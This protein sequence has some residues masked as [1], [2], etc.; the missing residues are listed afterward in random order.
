M[1]RPRQHNGSHLDFVRSLPCLICAD[2]TSTEAAHI[3]YG[4][5]RVAKRPAGFGEKSDDAFTVPMCGLHHRNQHKGNE[6]IFWRDVGID[7]IFIALALY[8]A[9]GD[10]EAGEQIISSAQTT[11]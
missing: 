5:P 10:H 3:K 9:S 4:D 8:R 2:N 6:R 1:K 11:G 7:P